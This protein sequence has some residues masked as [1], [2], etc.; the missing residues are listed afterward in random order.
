MT[1][2]PIVKRLPRDDDRVVHIS[3]FQI[4]D[5][6]QDRTT[7]ILR[8]FHSEQVDV[9]RYLLNIEKCKCRA[10]DYCF[11]TFQH[12]EDAARYKNEIK[13][14]PS[15]RWSG[16]TFSIWFCPTDIQEDIRIQRLQKLQHQQQQIQ[17][18][19]IQDQQ[20]EI[21]VAQ[22]VTEE[23]SPFEQQ[24]D[25]D[26]MEEES[27][28]DQQEDQDEIEE[29]KTLFEQIC[30]KYDNDME[31]ESIDEPQEDD[32]EEEEEE[33][34]AFDQQAAQEPQEDDMEEMSTDEPL[35]EVDEDDQ[36]W[37]MVEPPTEVF[38]KKIAFVC[39][40]MISLYQ[41]NITNGRQYSLAVRGTLE[42][43]TAMKEFTKEYNRSMKNI[44]D[45]AQWKDSD[46]FRKQLA[47]LGVSAYL[48]YSI[49]LVSKHHFIIVLFSFF[50]LI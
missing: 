26:S 39:L 5:R 33:E 43:V 4:A 6:Q 1:L 28:F 20:P 17:H 50:F 21:Q 13:V 35:E 24:N 49:V 19:Q 16:I 38:V 23:E 11:V 40:K 18:Q 34:S 2:I 27:A 3:G 31:V 46:Y 8:I 41:E 37:V 44:D 32:M 29:E 15:V 36:D 9:A 48:I 47:G 12:V 25:V 22:D 45:V 30:A 7:Q 42:Q 10:Q 14:F